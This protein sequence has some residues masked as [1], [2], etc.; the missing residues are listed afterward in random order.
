[1]S[2]VHRYPTIRVSYDPVPNAVSR[3]L[4]MVVRFNRPTLVWD[5]VNAVAP[6]V[7]LHALSAAPIAHACGRTAQRMDECEKNRPVCN[8]PLREGLMTN[9]DTE[10]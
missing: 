9:N 7:I 10:S 4:K 1:M 6:S 3:R 8:M 2:I 5:T